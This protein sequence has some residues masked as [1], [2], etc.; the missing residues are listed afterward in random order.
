MKRK[1]MTQKHEARVATRLDSFERWKA[2]KTVT[3]TLRRSDIAVIQ[4][5]AVSFAS[6]VCVS[7]AEGETPSRLFARAWKTIHCSG[8]DMTTINAQ[9]R[10]WAA[11][12]RA[13]GAVGA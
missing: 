2:A 7:G 11:T 1:Q 9:R 13:L 10:I 6:N 8:G 3:L 4:E 12:R 5:L